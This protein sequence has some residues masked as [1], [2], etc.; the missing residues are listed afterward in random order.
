[1]LDNKKILVTGGSGFLGT[2]FIKRLLD[3]NVK[4]IT[5][6]HN[7]ELRVKDEHNI[8]SFYNIDLENYEDCLKLVE[9]VDYV[10]HVAGPVGH[11]ATIKTDFELA[12]R[13]LNIFSNL[14]QSSN[15]CGVEKF[16]DI[17][18]STGYPDRRYPITED[19]YWDDD[20]YSSYFGYGWSK[21]YREKLMEHCSYFS[22]IK[23]IICRATAVY[24][25]YDNFNLETCHVIPALMKR[26]L[27]GENPLEV[28]GSPDVT[29][30]FLYIEDLVDGALLALE[31]G[32]SMRPYNLGYGETV[33]IGDI[34]NNLLDVSG[35]QPEI[36]WN[37]SKPTT[38]PFRMVSTERINNE[39]GFKP[40]YSL[41][42]GLKKTLEWYK[43]NK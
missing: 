29:R 11:P 31:S 2:N 39:L 6:V 24:G 14:L 43:E 8:E 30:D 23:F 4:I 19:E 3:F 7:T 5:H 12:R 25:P 38:I 32:E 41:H 1:M 21:R 37:N 33:T 27:S 13:H 28:W 16:L 18:S 10:I 9:N 22:N 26:L 36:V 35:I 15:E 34:V 42:D 20:P 40:K 17:N